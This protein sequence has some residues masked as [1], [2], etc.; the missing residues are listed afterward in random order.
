VQCRQNAWL[1]QAKGK[2]VLGR[3]DASYMLTHIKAQSAKFDPDEVLVLVGAFNK[4]WQSVLT[5]G[6]Q[7]DGDAG[8]IRD[9]LAINIIESAKK[10]ERSQRRLSQDALDHL[11]MTLLSAPR[12]QIQKS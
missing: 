11:A 8:T 2:R 10:G 9:V 12:S 5:R 6:A 7:L 1:A 4:A 3:L